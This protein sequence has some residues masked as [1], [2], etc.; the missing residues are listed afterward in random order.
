VPSVVA[1]ADETLALCHAVAEAGRGI[2]HIA[3]G[4]TFEWVYDLAE[5]FPQ[6][7]TWSAILAYPPAKPVNW[8]HKL[9]LHAERLAAGRAP[10][11]HP[12]VTSRILTFQFTIANPII[13][14]G[15]PAFGQL[16]RA[17]NDDARTAMLRDGSWRASA[18]EQADALPVNW[19]SIIVDETHD[20]A[21]AGCN[22]RAVATRR[23]THPV[24]ALA[25]LALADGLRTRLVVA[26]ANT[27]QDAV[28][29]LLSAPGCILGLTDA[30]AHVGQLCDAAMAL[31]FLAEYV[32]DRRLMS[33][34]AG[35]RKVSAEIAEV[36][37]L[38]GRGTLHAGA[39]AD[40]VVIDWDR[41][42]PGPVIRTHDLPGGADRLVANEPA[43]LHHVLV[44]GTFIRRDGQAAANAPLS[45]QV[46]GPKRYRA[47]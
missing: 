5:A 39:H 40:I 23:G 34:E 21:A 28:G 35:L 10:D 29:T 13:L 47:R 7:I 18:R 42:S 41:L 6:T 17:V 26:A 14:Y 4:D 43:G 15:C 11:V 24:D 1:T 12:Q 9:G 31:H 44:N 33:M 46:L 37:G 22:M 2:V 30:G 32:R 45:G 16:A 19:D 3:P 27:D 38:D 36:V 20:S 8:Q 25:D